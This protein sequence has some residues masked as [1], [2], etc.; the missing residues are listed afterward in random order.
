M[1]A[2]HLLKVEGKMFTMDWAEKLFGI[3][4]A[5]F[6]VIMSLIVHDYRQH[7]ESTNRKFLEMDMSRKEREV[8]R[9]K[10]QEFSQ[11]RAEALHDANLDKI[12]KIMEIQMSSLRQE[13]SGIRVLIA[14]SASESSRTAADLWSEIKTLRQ[15]HRNR[16]DAMFSEMAKLKERVKDAET[17]ARQ[18]NTEDV[19]HI[20]EAQ[21]KPLFDLMNRGG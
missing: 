2:H 3:I 7:K 11:N 19:K 16:V 1:R 8:E 18:T 20:L 15:E 14:E 21:L 13:F 9:D 12:G 4:L 5:L 6:G 10:V 17:A